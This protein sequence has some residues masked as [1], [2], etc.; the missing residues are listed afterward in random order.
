MFKSGRKVARLGP[1]EIILYILQSQAGSAGLKLYLSGISLT[2]Q[3]A[4]GG[5]PKMFLDSPA[6]H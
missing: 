5:H 3:P 6:G 2:S 1:Q 4:C